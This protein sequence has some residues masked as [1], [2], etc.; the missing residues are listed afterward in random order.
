MLSI[1]MGAVDSYS[2]LA[3]STFGHDI[4]PRLKKAS[5]S[6]IVKLTRLGLF[7]SAGLSIIWA[8]FFRSAVDIWYAFGSIGTP[9]LL[10]PVVTSMVGKRRMSGAHAFVATVSSGLISLIWYLSKYLSETGEYWLKIQPIFPGLAV[11]IVIFFTS[12]RPISGADLP[13]SKL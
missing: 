4:I 6:Q 10:I 13:Q 9:A 12:A 8:L 2:F 1:I 3:A 5:E 7:V 11:S